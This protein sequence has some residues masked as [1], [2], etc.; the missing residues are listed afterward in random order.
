[1]DEYEEFTLLKAK[2]VKSR[3]VWKCCECGK[4]IQIGEEYLYEK[5]KCEGT[6]YT[7]KTCLDCVKVRDILFCNGFYYIQLWETLREHLEYNGEI[8]E[9]C[10]SQLTPRGREMVC[11]LIERNWDDESS[12]L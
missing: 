1:V 11:E 3:G 4:D 12:D 10:I 9:N 8:A 2:V 6:F 5:G 7:Y